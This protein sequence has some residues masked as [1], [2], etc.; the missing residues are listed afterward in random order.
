MLILID[1][2]AMMMILEITMLREKVKGAWVAFAWKL[3]H[4]QWEDQKARKS[5]VRFKNHSRRMQSRK[6]F[7]DSKQE[8]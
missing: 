5:K 8:R 3:E 7:F 1:T 2:I 6:G 4:L